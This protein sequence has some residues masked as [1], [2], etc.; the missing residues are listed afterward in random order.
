MVAAPYQTFYTPRAGRVAGTKRLPP[1]S[2]SEPQYDDLTSRAYDASG[3]VDW[4]GN[5]VITTA[6][7]GS[8][9]TSRY[10]RSRSYYGAD[11]R[12]RYYQEQ[13]L[14]SSGTSVQNL[15]VWE[16]YRY[17]PLGRRVLVRSNRDDLCDQPDQCVSH[18]TRYVWSGDQ[19][20]WELR[21]E[22]GNGASL[23]SESSMGAQ[24]GRVSYFHAGG[25]DRPLVIMKNDTSIIP[26]QNWRGQFAFGT[27]ANGQVSDCNGW[28]SPCSNV[29]WPGFRT[30]AWHVEANAPDIRNWYGGL[31]DGMRDA[32]GQMYMRNRYYDPATGQF[33]QTDPIGLAGGLNSYGFAAGDPVTYSDPYGL[34][35]TCDEKAEAAQGRLCAIVVT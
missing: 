31:V 32:S 10:A 25:I 18:I 7:D 14:V 26:H 5:E 4:G 15:G 16:E 24:H 30:T 17:D 34:K 3:N 21:A 13:V 11:E 29:P 23:E 20:L 27:Y 8:Q 33:T 9:F 35:P 6:P 22:G 28:R 19:V 2:L 1:S 12:L